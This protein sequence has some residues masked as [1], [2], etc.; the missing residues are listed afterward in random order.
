MEYNVLIYLHKNHDRLKYVMPCRS[1][2]N[3]VSL[4]GFSD[5]S[6]I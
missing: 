4:L 6:H 5:S 1:Y 3:D 2:K